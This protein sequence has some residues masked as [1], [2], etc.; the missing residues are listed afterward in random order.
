[1]HG[2]L[3]LGK[4]GQTEVFILDLLLVLLPSC[5]SPQELQPA[6][7]CGF[8]WFSLLL[9]RLTCPRF[10]RARGKVSFSFLLFSKVASYVSACRGGAQGIFLAM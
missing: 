1:M 10:T 8:T 3:W 5:V 7:V 6:Q 2:L 4:N 9:S